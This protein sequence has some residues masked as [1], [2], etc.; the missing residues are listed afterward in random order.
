MRILKILGLVAALT[1]GAHGIAAAQDAGRPQRL[2]LAERFV[3]LSMGSEMDR[4][5]GSLVEEQLAETPDMGAAEREWMRANMPT[6]TRDFLEDL[7]RELAVVY[8]D[9]FTTE[10]L[11][12]LV[13][14]YATP[15]GQSIATKQFE[16]G[17]RSQE[18]MMG[19]LVRFLQKLEAK[20]CAEF[21]CEDAGAAASRTK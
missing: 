19:S 7:G 16:I 13:A 18:L 17:A 11:Q 20:F 1:L 2:E 14:F 12:A 9:E 8:A 5:L 3:Q 15:L 6:L 4:M 21:S 10:E